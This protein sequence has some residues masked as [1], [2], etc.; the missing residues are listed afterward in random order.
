MTSIWR[1]KEKPKPARSFHFENDATAIFGTQDLYFTFRKIRVSALQTC[2]LTLFQP[3]QTN[4]VPL[5]STAPHRKRT[6]RSSHKQ[7]THLQT[8]TQ[9]LTA[10]THVRRRSELS[11]GLSVR[12]SSNQRDN[13][14]HRHHLPPSF[15]HYL[16]TSHP[17]LL[18]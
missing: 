5:A 3:N 9:N 7:L 4:L 13:R 2:I 12:A 14:R 16:T 8:D 1:V 15:P 18:L 17:F 10:N 11:S 6:S